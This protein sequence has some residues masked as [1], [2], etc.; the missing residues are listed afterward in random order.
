MY[1]SDGT[2]GVVSEFQTLSVVILPLDQLELANKV[3]SSSR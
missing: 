3:L 2:R 1:Y